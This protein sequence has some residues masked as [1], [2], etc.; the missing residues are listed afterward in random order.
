M[1]TLK[2]LPDVARRM[3]ELP[4]T[5]SHILGELLCL[6]AGSGAKQA[7]HLVAKKLVY[8]GMTATVSIIHVSRFA[9]LLL[10]VRNR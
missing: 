3:V 7:T 8:N 6:V 10:R 2:V 5:R 4:L 1:P 9:W